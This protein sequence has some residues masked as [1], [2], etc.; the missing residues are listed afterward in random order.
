MRRLSRHAVA[1]ASARS[2]LECLSGA[3]R[4][5]FRAMSRS[6]L[7]VVAVAFGFSA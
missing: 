5:D 4:Y 6:D 1:L 7:D 2:F 3:R